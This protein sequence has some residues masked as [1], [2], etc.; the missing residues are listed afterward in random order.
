[1]IPHPNRVPRLPALDGLRGMAAIG[2]VLF[3][4]PG[5]AIIPWM[6][7]RFYLLVDVFFLL[8]GFVMALSAEPR[9]AAGW[10]TADF[11]IARLRRLWPTMA[12]GIGLGA[13]AFLGRY[14]P[15]QIAPFALLALF[16]LPVPGTRGLAYPING[17]EWSLTWELA[18]NLIHAVVLRRLSDRALIVVAAVSGLSLAITAHKVGCGCA[19]PNAANWYWAA[20]RV[21]WAY[22]LGMVLGRRW[23]QRTFAPVLDWKLALASP[24]LALVLLPWLPLT[25]AL[26]DTLMT[27]LVLPGLFWLICV[28]KPPPQMVRGLEKLGAISFP[29]YATHPAALLACSYLGPSKAFLALGLVAAVGGA[30]MIAW[31]GAQLKHRR[32]GAIAMIPPHRSP[33]MRRTDRLA[34]GP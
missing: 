7:D 31:A 23:R 20:P 28:A 8:S 22:T 11:M 21:A 6:F 33:V 2:I 17:P 15:S 13:I 27:L 30:G 29:L 25:Q 18:A 14:P 12:L 34:G 4:L 1:M 16:M 19:G 32:R 26:G 9:L 3:H 24:I 10:S 5:L